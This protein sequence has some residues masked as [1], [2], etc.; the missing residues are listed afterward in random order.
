MHLP[1]SP[2]AMVGGV[3][4]RTAYWVTNELPP[5]REF[6]E[7]L[8]LIAAV[9]V[10]GWFSPLSFHALGHVYLLTVII[11]SLRVSR[12]PA[13]VAAVVSALAWD[14]AFI[15]PKLSFSVLDVD[16]SLLLGTYFVV[17]LTAGQLTTRIRDQQR[18]EH[19]REQHATALFH[20]TRALAG[21]HTL[22]EGVA[23][24]LS[25]AD[26]LFEAKSALLLAADGAPLTAH[27][28]GSLSPDEP[29]RALAA[30]TWRNRHE[31][32]RFTDVSPEAM[33]LHLPL[34]RGRQV[35]GVLVIQPPGHA[36]HLPQQQH[37][38]LEGF[39]AQIAVLVE[40]EILR[41]ASERAKLLAESDR[42]HRTLL[43]SVSHELKTPLAVL[44]AAAESLARDGAGRRPELP[45][46]ILAAVRRLN[47]VVSN[48]LSQSRLEAGGLRPKLDWCDARDLIAGA[49]REL[50]DALAG[51]L[52]RVEIP[53]DMPLLR[54]DAP[55]MEHVITN[56]LLNAV[57]YSPAGSA[58]T[59]TGGLDPA[60][61]RV[62]L[63]F[64][65]EGPGLPPDLLSQPFQRFKRG[66]PLGGKGL[67][68]GLSIVRGLMQAQGGD[69]TV[70]EHAGAGARL[71]VYL[72][73]RPHALVPQE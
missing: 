71:T 26:M 46:E 49:R 2:P 55:L 10:A 12:W 9:S 72:P 17:A 42:L 48:L 58:L 4:G 65:D 14:Y 34:L 30:W 62:S 54:A 43:D 8:L 41:S 37:D 63:T 60:T 36:T 56:L 35:L 53:V 21:T 57:L 6:A 39:A 28:A 38:L 69:V 16:E 40:R 45:T 61:A 66:D 47:R 64:A 7:V 52:F 33:T 50:G 23:V 24:A 3:P 67:G 44:Q 51:R 32:G 5:W 73:H 31:A 59:V 15:P 20:L 29:T 1:P 25:R 70:D 27:A 22:D 18:S 68:L 19:R 13:L 11:L